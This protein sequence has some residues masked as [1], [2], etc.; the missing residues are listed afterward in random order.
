MSRRIKSTLTE[1]HPLAPR[2]IPQIALGSGFVA[3]LSAVIACSSAHTV[4]AGSAPD[5]RP[6]AIPGPPDGE[7]VTWDNWASYFNVA[8]CVSCHNPLAPC[9]GNGCHNA[10]TPSY[11]VLFDFRDR[12]AFVARAPV[13]RCGVAHQQDPSW[14]CGRTA[15]ETYPKVFGNNPIPSDV[16]RAMLVEWI[17]ASCP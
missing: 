14:D 2:G 13:I 8:Y 7:A 5:A 17:D 11:D 16:Q 6:V 10:G 3:L 15:P 9:G 1:L 4:A 12:S